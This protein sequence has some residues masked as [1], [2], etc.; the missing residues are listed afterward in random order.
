MSYTALE[1]MRDINRARFGCDVGPF[2]PE[3]HFS[4]GNGLKDAALRFIHD[5]CEGLRF[6][7]VT[8]RMEAENGEYRGTA[9]RPGQIPYD[10]QMDIDRLCLER[11]LERFIESGVADDA[12]NVYYCYLEMFF[13]HYGR[14]KKMIELLSE[15][16]S[17]G[18][19]LLMKHRDHYSHSVYVFT[20]GLAIYETNSHYREAFKRFY[21]FD[22]DEGSAEQDYAAANAFIEFWGLTSLFHD[23]GYPFELPFEQ[24][25]AYFEV[26]KYKRGKQSVVIAYRSL[27]L[28]TRISDEARARFEEL[29]GRSFAATDELFAYDIVAKLGDIYGIEE[30]ALLEKLRQKPTDPEKFNYFMDHA[31]FSAARLYQEL[32]KPGDDGSS[33]AADIQKIHI[34]A[35]TAIL[36][37]NSLYKFTVTFYKDPAKP[38]MK[39]EYHPLAFMLML[40]DELQCWDRIAYGR[41]SRRELHPMGASFDFGGNAVKAVYYY[42]REERAKIDAYEA[43]YQKWEDDGADPDNEPRLKA[44][45]DMADKK[46]RFK[47]DIELIVDTSFCPLTVVADVRRADR[48]VKHTYLSNSSFLH[49]YDFAVALNA[50]YNYKGAEKDTDTERLEKE[51]EELSLEYQLS[52]INQAKNFSRYLN[53]I[54]CFYTDKPVDFEMIRRFTPDQ[55]AAFAPLEHERWIR[56]HISMGWSAGDLYE[57]AELPKGERFLGDSSGYAYRKAYREQLRMHKLCMSGDPASE[58]IN[59]HYLSLP[60]DEQGKDWEPFNNMLR[61]IKMYDGLRI[62][63]LS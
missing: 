53:E 43:A 11:E 2:P 40:C 63:K 59:A 34:D 1:K 10:M 32:T 16:E 48:S 56:E 57:T 17:N 9:I 8:E 14:S 55:T 12:Y 60:D 47:S 4:D 39:M 7:P 38:R 27:D 20:L 44:Y 25:M 50:R 6:D 58:E 5:R 41:N 49:L 19:S 13:G 45:S 21:G 52:N 36:L 29:Y 26:D 33:G 46:Q 15:F 54:G 24:V 51:F 18:S 42:D 23:I 37:H 3:R 31:W 35:L 30:D 28:L 61:L 22:T 62:Y